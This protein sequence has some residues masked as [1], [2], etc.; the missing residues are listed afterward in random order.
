[1][2]MGRAGYLFL[3]QMSAAPRVQ[4]RLDGS[5]AYFRGRTPHTT[6]SSSLY[7]KNTG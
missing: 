4:R 3:K 5:K 7:A 1:M 2:K 6:G